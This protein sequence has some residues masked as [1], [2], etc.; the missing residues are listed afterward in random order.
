MPSVAST[1]IASVSDRLVIAKY[2]DLSSVAMY[3]FAFQISSMVYIIGDAVTRVISPV[4]MSGL[5]QDK[6][7]THQKYNLLQSLCGE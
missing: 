7:S 6:Q 3:S 4:I 2:V 5:V 1:W